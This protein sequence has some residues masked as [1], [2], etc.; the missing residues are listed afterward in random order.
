MPASAMQGGHNQQL[1][2]LPNSFWTD[3]EGV[4]TG[5]AGGSGDDTGGVSSGTSA[6]QITFNNTEMHNIY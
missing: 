5:V 1:N 4:V 2:K 3:C 6:A